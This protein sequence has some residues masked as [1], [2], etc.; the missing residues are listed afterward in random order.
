MCLSLFK[1]SIPLICPRPKA[2]PQ[3][4][5]HVFYRTE[6]ELKSIPQTALIRFYATSLTEV[7][8]N[9]VPLHQG[10]C[11]S[12]LP[13]LYFD[14][15]PLSSLGTGINVFSFHQCVEQDE[16]EFGMR[17]ELE[18]FDGHTHSYHLQTTEN[19]R[20]GYLNTYLSDTPSMAGAGY[21][22]HYSL[23]AD[24]SEWFNPEF[25]KCFPVAST[26]T[27][28]FSAKY[29]HPR[30]IPLFQEK[31]RYPTSIQREPSGSLLADFADM[32]FGRVELY[33]HSSGTVR[34][35][36]IE[37]LCGGWRSPEGTCEMYEDHIV[38][39]DGSFHWKSF[40]KRAFRYIRFYNLSTEKLQLKVLE[41]GYPVK[42][43]GSF[44]CSDNFL[45]RLAD[46]S[47]RTLEICMDDFYNDC[48]HRDQKQWMDAFASAQ[49]ALGL[50]GVRDLAEKCLQQYA[51]TADH[52]KIFSPSLTR[53]AWVPDYSLLLIVFAKWFYQV[54]GDADLLKTIYPE[55][56]KSLDEFHC[57]EQDN[58]LAIMPEPPDF[59]YLDNAL[60]LSKQGR[61]AGLNALYYRALTD[62]AAIAEILNRH[63]DCSRLRK[64]AERVREAFLDTFQH[65]IIPE[66]FTDSDR[67]WDEAFYL[68]NFS[69]EL[70]HWHGEK[71]VLEFII[72][73]DSDAERIM[74]YSDYAGMKLYINEK[75]A[76]DRPRIPSWGKQPAY[77]PERLALPLT[78]GKNRIRFEVY[79]N[80]LNWEL[81]F[82]FPNEQGMKISDAMVS[83]CSFNDKTILTAARP[84]R[85]RR[86]HPPTLSQ[87]TQGYVGFAGIYPTST[88]NL[89]MLRQVL[90]EE[91]VRTYLSIRVPYFCR[92][93]GEKQELDPWIMP[94][95]TPWS[96]FFLLSSLFENGGHLEGME[97]IR[98]YWSKMVASGSTT[99]WEEWGNRSSLCHAWG[100]VPIYFMQRYVLGVCHDKLKDNVLIIR[101]WLYNL[102]FA[103]GAVALDTDPDHAVQL[104]LTREKSHTRL[105][106]KAPLYLRVDLRTDLLPG[107]IIDPHSSFRSLE[108]SRACQNTVSV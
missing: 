50:F 94:A 41:Y 12:H 85:L 34:I 42:R 17:C 93:A 37:D 54:S 22:E 101:P 5:L 64:H 89:N 107:C 79:S 45:N 75:L 39:I 11:R 78:C 6:F 51:V 66:C 108:N 102:D 26:T 10:P 29:W 72:D 19:F 71:G 56:I 24:G 33:G 76:F 57:Y 83:E 95:N 67:Y 7:A 43:I 68:V 8:V 15:I 99:T 90:S 86:W 28:L 82:R 87:T 80:G 74:E 88:A 21:A 65:P 1:Q 62:L 44:S 104:K 48:P 27:Q 46:I 106:L 3:F 25:G 70:H 20:C 63:N 31:P 52:N 84:L 100:A 18:I 59:V 47:T 58:L 9:G 69:C 14:E 105:Q 53:E 36:Y 98:C 96:T 35:A 97:I 55:L 103:E 4:P 40:H 13:L 2:P 81:F 16:P 60:E 23:Q 77:S 30:P 73:T 38:D 91:Y 49:A 32:V 61:S 92:E